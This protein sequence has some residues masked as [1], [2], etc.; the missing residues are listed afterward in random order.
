M[1]QPHWSQ[2]S[3]E[4]FT[5]TRD[6]WLTD[7]LGVES[8]NVFS[9][10][11][12]E[13]PAAPDLTEPLAGPAFLTAKVPAR[14]IHTVQRLS[15]LGFYIVDTALTF[16]FESRDIPASVHRSA[17]D[18]LIWTVTDATPDDA[19]SVGLIASEALTTSRFHLDPGI[20]AARASMIKS[21]WARSLALGHRGIGCRVVRDA[22][23][24]QGFLG[25]IQGKDGQGIFIIDLIAVRSDSQGRGAGAA[26]VR[27]FLI[28]AQ[29]QGVLAQVGTQAA[30]I[31][32]VR[33]Y[34]RLGFTLVSTTYVMHAHVQAEEPL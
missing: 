18:R 30:N 8:W 32:A 5:R 17:P 24:V 25:T 19:D 20:T 9:A 11:Q 7:V 12:I 29:A 15:E 22:N 13:A 31:A 1:A 33:F 26:L 21:A 6:D 3:R 23:G 27:D 16:R 14:N 4:F 34:E 2:F 10:T 28:R